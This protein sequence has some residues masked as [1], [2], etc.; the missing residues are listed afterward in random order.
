[1]RNENNILRSNGL[2]GIVSCA[3]NTEITNLNN[4]IKDTIEKK[5]YFLKKLSET[6]K[7]ITESKECLSEI[8][9]STNYTEKEIIQKIKDLQTVYY[10][11]FTKSKKWIKKVSFLKL[12]HKEQNNLINDFD[13]KYLFFN[14]SEEILFM[15][16]PK[17]AKET[18]K[19][20]LEQRKAEEKEVLKILRKTGGKN[21]K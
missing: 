15:E 6:K 5:E 4:S 13:E 21:G 14:R 9:K 8:K 3:R 20:S 18:G 11:I 10:K 2:P 17:E 1:M 19:I 12:P 7:N 16:L